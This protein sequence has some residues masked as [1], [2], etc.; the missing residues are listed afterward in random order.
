MSWNRALVLLGAA[1]VIVVLAL[2]LI[3]FDSGDSYCGSVI[4]R[5]AATP[6]CNRSSSIRIVIGLGVTVAGVGCI[7]I[8]RG[9]ARDASGRRSGPRRPMG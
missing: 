1:L 3:P 5:K 7:V 6:V 9:L 4:L 8:G 2:L